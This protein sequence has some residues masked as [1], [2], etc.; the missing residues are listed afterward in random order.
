[1]GF[2]CLIDGLF[3]YEDELE[4]DELEEEDDDD[5]LLELDDYESDRFLFISLDLLLYYITLSTISS[6]IFY[7]SKIFYYL[8]I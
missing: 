8:S 6:F 5:E 2:W 4:D 1:M 3:A 7:T